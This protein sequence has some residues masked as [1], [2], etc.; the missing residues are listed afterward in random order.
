MELKNE[1][2]ISQRKAK[3]DFEIGICRNTRDWREIEPA[4]NFGIFDTQDRQ[5]RQGTFSSETWI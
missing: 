5:I 3:Q 1:I 4:I 2:L